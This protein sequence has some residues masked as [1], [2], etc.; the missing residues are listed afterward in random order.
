MSPTE[1]EYHFVAEKESIPAKNGEKYMNGETSSKGTGSDKDGDEK[2]EE[3]QEV[4]GFFE[5]VSES[6]T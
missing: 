4:V 3:K 6:R 1:E 5:L 2:K